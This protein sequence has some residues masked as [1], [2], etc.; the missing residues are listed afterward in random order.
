M[1]K[2]TRFII[3]YLLLAATALYLN[4]HSDIAVPPNKPLMEFPVENRGWRMVS[5]SEFSERV[6][7]VLKPTD[8]LYRQYVAPDGGVVGLYIGFHGGGKGCGGIHSP[9]NCLPGSGWYQCSSGKSSIQVKSGKL[10]L[11]K[12]VYQKGESSELFL[13]WFQVKG[14]A[15]TD[16]YSLKLAEIMNSIKYRR[17]DSAFIRISVPF[18]SDEK[19]AVETGTRFIRDFYPVIRGFLPS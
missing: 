5:Q 15:L 1:I 12:A 17:R 3:V 19:K 14:I 9:K 13:Y 16:E 18:Q 2:S 7:D 4:L 8:Y 11:V 6:L 10:D